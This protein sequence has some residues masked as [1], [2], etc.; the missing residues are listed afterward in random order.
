MKPRLNYMRMRNQLFWKRNHAF[1]HKTGIKWRW[2]FLPLKVGCGPRIV[3][4]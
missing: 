3:K 2:F 1:S 4:K